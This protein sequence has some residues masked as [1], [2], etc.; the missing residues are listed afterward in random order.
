MPSR[1]PNH[2]HRHIEGNSEKTR[3][4]VEQYYGKVAI[5]NT[6]ESQSDEVQSRNHAYI[7]RLRAEIRQIRS[8][9]LH[10]AGPDADVL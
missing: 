8:Y 2:P 5:L 7:I 10:R 3:L 9:V 1:N 6:W 4:R